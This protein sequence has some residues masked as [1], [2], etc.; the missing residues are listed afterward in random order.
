M[1]KIKPFLVFV[2]IVFVSVSF[3]T[4]PLPAVLAQNSPG[5]AA[6]VASFWFAGSGGLNYVAFLAT[7]VGAQPVTI[8]YTIRSYNATVVASGCS[9]NDVPSYQNVGWVHYQKNI[10]F[11]GSITVYSKNSTTP[12]APFG[13]LI[14]DQQGNGTTN[15]AVSLQWFPIPPP[16]Q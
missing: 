16:S 10:G 9:D 3:P 8:C 15:A 7:N 1:L 4:F 14:I 12:I 2:T 13:D 5:S 11:S 6:Y